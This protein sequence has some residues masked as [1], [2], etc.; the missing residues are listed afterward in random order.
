MSSLHTATPWKTSGSGT[1]V[2]NNQGALLAA[3]YGDDPQCRADDRMH[4]NAEFIVRACNAHE[5]LVTELMSAL[6]FVE[7]AEGSNDFKPGAVTARIKSIRAAL[8]KAGAV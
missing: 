6:C 8:A 5:D 3:V 1:S 7:D 2:Y 4:A